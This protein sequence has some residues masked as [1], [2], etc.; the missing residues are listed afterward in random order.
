MRPLRGDALTL[1]YFEP[2]NAPS[3]G[4]IAL[5]LVAHDYRGV[6]DM[7][8]PAG[9]PQGDP[10]NRSGG[11]G[12]GCEVDVTC[13]LGNGWE[14]QAK[15]CVK[16][17][18]LSAGAFCS[19]S[20]LN[21]TAN[22]GTL[23]VLSA[24]HCGDLSTAVFSFDFQMPA[25]RSGT[26]SGTDITGSTPLVMDYYDAD[27]DP[28]VFKEGG[29]DVQLVR[30]VAPQGPAAFPVFLAG[31]DRSDIA[32][33]ATALIHHPGGTPKK[34]SRDFDPPGKVKDPRIGSMQILGEFWRIFTWER[35]V[36]EGGSSGAPL[37][38]PN[39]RFIGN[40]DS[41]ASDCV[42]PN[43]DLCTRLAVAWPVLAPYLDPLGTGQ[44]T[45]DGLDLATVTPQPFTVTGILPTQIE[46]VDP[47]PVRTLRILGTGFPDT[48][49]V[50]VNGLTLNPF[51][52]THS[53]H[54][55]INIDLPPIRIGQFRLG[56][57]N[58]TA[59]T[60]FPLRVVSV[61]QPKYQFGFGTVNEPV[62]T[63]L[64][65]DTIYADIPG[66]VHYCFWS[67]SNVPSIHPVLSLGLGNNFTDVRHCLINPIPPEGFLRLHR[68]F[69]PGLV[70]PGTTIYTQAACVTHGGRTF[71]ASNL[72]QFVYQL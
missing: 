60:E 7:V 62:F 19:G 33:A 5:S 58:G 40:M 72:Q 54:S 1:E 12:G 30:I 39:R 64:D 4:E 56:V 32:P 24:G 57:R 67:L 47:S 16:I 70:P 42:V 49:E 50:T 3:P 31:W 68:D 22:D 26:P 43:N 52:F 69:K 55:F 61:T 53:G 44:L 63:S 14:N 34:I 66:H 41:G 48:L 21:N 45:L 6:L 37:F 18:S 38:D 10:T 29:S 8:D 15:A 71:P 36:T 17:L 27:P 9:D 59:I 46:T 11:G 51:F 20:L 23:L 35:G 2:A 65:T 25:C 28:R 13:A